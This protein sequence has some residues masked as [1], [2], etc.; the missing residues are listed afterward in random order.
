MN[1]KGAHFS[2]MSQQTHTPVRLT[3]EQY[4]RW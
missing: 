4:L 3:F 2:E 1:M